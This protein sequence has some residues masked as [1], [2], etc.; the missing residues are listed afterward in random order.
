MAFVSC[1]TGHD[2]SIIALKTH[3]S[4]NLPPYMIPDQFKVVG[5][6]PRT[7]TDKV[8]LQALRASA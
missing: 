6:L 4:K 5:A 2:L 3:S 1:R 8:D 7:S